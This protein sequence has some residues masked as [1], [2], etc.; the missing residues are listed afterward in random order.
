MWCIRCYPNGK[1]Q[2][3]NF[4]V[5][6]Q[7]CGLP[8]Q[9]DKLEVSWSIRCPGTNV[10][11]GWTTDFDATKS[12][13]GWGADHFTFDD[14]QLCQSFEI[15]VEVK[16]ESEENVEAMRIWEHQANEYGS[17]YMNWDDAEEK[18]FLEASNGGNSD[19][20]VKEIEWVP[21]A[22]SAKK[23]PK[24]FGAGVADLKK[25][26]KSLRKEKKIEEEKLT[27][28][29]KQMEEDVDALEQKTEGYGHTPAMTKGNTMHM[30]EEQKVQHWL[31]EVVNLPDYAQLLIDEGF[32]ELN[33]LKDVTKED[34][35]AMGIKKVGH[36]RRI[37]KHS[38][39]L[40]NTPM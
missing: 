38:A 2:R 4:L 26:M 12:C 24:D 40:T 22:K 25:Q 33:L 18:S 5:Q 13:W 6:L 1:Q 29:V 20:V 9:A 35:V 21:P 39:L 19:G 37:L 30:S 32:D 8:R 23:K 16:A 36:Q 3:G 11:V 28:K 31:K 27:K 7:L 15:V 14:F 17:T 34:L 10:E